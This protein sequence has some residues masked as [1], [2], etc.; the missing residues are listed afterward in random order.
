METN[1]LSAGAL[2][3]GS[4]V[5]QSFCALGFAHL[6][7]EANDTKGTLGV[8]RTN[9]NRAST[10]PALQENGGTIADFNVEDSQPQELVISDDE[11]PWEQVEMGSPDATH[12]AA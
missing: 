8:E 10:S 1:A 5:K 6:N 4:G 12:P 2:S 7:T 9:T 3:C 11:K